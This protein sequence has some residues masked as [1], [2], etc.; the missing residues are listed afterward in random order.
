MSTQ[1]KLAKSAGKNLFLLA[2]PKAGCYNAN[3]YLMNKQM[4]VKKTQPCNDVQV[5][6]IDLKVAGGKG[7][8]KL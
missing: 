4:S 1:N 2:I 7:R 6:L 3:M 5:V 8:E